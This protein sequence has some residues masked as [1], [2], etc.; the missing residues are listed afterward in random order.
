MQISLVGKKPTV[1]QTTNQD[2]DRLTVASDSRW[3]KWWQKYG[4]TEEQ[5][6]LVVLGL[7]PQ[8]E[9]YLLGLMQE[10]L[11]NGEVLALE[12]KIRELNLE[13]DEASD[14]YG[15]AYREKTGRTFADEVEKYL[16][17][18]VDELEK[19]ETD[20]NFADQLVALDKLPDAEA[21]EKLTDIMIDKLGI[22]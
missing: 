4:A 20:Q 7:V 12:R 19:L 9:L 13:L 8:L 6:T 2:I 16:D 14:F 5:L 11:N 17:S 3:A 10:A 1:T 15:L 18:L 22:K 21:V